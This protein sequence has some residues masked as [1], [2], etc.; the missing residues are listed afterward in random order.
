PLEYFG[1][2]DGLRRTGGRKARPACRGEKGVAIAHRKRLASPRLTGI[3]D[4]RPRSA[5][6][7]G[8]GP[9]PG[10]LEIAT[11][12][13]EVVLGPGALDHVDPFLRVIVAFFVLAL[14]DPEHGKFAFVPARHQVQAEAAAADVVGGNHLLGSDDRMEQ[15]SVYCSENRDALCR[16]KKPAGPGDGFERRPVEVTRTAV[17]LP[18]TD[19]QKEIDAS[20][21]RHA[22]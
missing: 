18:A 14:R 1:F 8:L 6:R 2:V 5:D 9:N 12:E 19:W 11:V 20:I 22:R 3:H 13:I 15:W 16:G 17:A 4:D 10:Q 21:V 7:L